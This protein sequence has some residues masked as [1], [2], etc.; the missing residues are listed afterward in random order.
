MRRSRNCPSKGKGFWSMC[1]VSDLVFLPLFD[2]L[3]WLYG[4]F[5][6]VLVSEF[7]FFIIDFFIAQEL[8][9][10]PCNISHHLL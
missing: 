5:L 4:L 7:M 9:C 1:C 3:S 10:I 8:I 2:F 6:L